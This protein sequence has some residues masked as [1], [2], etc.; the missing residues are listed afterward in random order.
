MAIHFPTTPRDVEA[1]TAVFDLL[2][3]LYSGTPECPRC[4]EA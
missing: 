4:G 1:C 2:A 3:R